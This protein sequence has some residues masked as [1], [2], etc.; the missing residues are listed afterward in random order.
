MYS[1]REFKYMFMWL[2]GRI[3]L[4]FVIQLLK[5][6]CRFEFGKLHITPSSEL[7]K[8]PPCL[9]WV[10]NTRE[11]NTTLM[12]KGNSEIKHCD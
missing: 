8:T 5:V 1:T 4:E 7:W 11:Q 12:N 10:A 9:E 2:K 6:K 3:Y